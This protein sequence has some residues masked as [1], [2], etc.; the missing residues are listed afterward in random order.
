MSNLQALMQDTQKAYNDKKYDQAVHG[1]QKIMAIEPDNVSVLLMM[2]DIY[3]SQNDNEKA[4]EC[5]QKATQIDPHNAIGFRII[6]TAFLQE[7]KLD[8]A[9]KALEKSLNL[10]P[11]DH[12]CLNNMGSSYWRS[13]DDNRII[14]AVEFYGNALI[15]NSHN[16]LYINNFLNAAGYLGTRVF[17]AEFKNLLTHCFSVENANHNKAR[18]AWV[19]HYYTDPTFKRLCELT[20]AGNI[21]KLEEYLVSEDASA[22]LQ[23]RYLALGLKRLMPGSSRFELDMTMLRQALLNIAQQ[24]K[25]NDNLLAFTHVMAEHCWLNEFLFFVTENEQKTLQIIKDT[26]EAIKSGHTSD[27]PEDLLKQIL[28]YACYYPLLSLKNFEAVKS[29]LV[30]NGLPETKHLVTMH[31]DERLEE[32]EIAKTIPDLIG[33][34]KDNV[35]NAVREQYE[36]NPYPRWNTA[37]TQTNDIYDINAK[38]VLLAGCGTGKQSSVIQAIYPNAEKIL[39]IDLSRASISYAIRKLKQ[40]GIWTDILDFRHGDIL[41]LNQLD[42]KFDAIHC[43]GVLHHMSDPIEGWKNLL[44]CL[45]DDGKIHISLYSKIAREALNPAKNIIKTKAF[46]YSADDIRAF[47]HMMLEPENQDVLEGISRFGDYFSISSCRDL[48]FHVQEHQF[49]LEDIQKITD[50]LGLEFLEFRL[51]D[52]N[53]FNSYK[54]MFPNDP[55][56]TNLSN[57]HVFEKQNPNTFISMYQMSFKKKPAA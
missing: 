26:I 50:D 36:Q 42:E 24:G 25:M 14:K 20:K 40:L 32:I 49:T 12:V 57:W 6:G 52:A 23:D 29:I 5:A 53:V 18:G 16:M 48:L 45:K 15:K 11:N 55:A 19:I 44:S 21:T 51:R 37:Q 39:N 54:T 31:I 2:S 30:E 22:F 8:E 4:I 33:N 34:I 43:D 27:E 13:N 17:N 3:L 28:I 46:G 10:N 9:R 1:C 41:N 47:R 35:S 7:N 38:N 56:C